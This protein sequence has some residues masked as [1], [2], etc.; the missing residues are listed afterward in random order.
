MFTLLPSCGCERARDRAAAPALDDN[1]EPLL[2]FGWLQLSFRSGSID[3]ID[4]GLRVL[5]FAQ[6]ST[7]AIVQ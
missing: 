1:Q 4:R 6:T 3:S 7:L 2:I 5:V